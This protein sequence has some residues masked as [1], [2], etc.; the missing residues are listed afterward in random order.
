M[1]TKT[2]V[3]MFEG[4]Y[5]Y[6]DAPLKRIGHPVSYYSAQNFVL[7]CLRVMSYEYGPI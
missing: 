7:L 1:T 4:I 3:N 5:I 2:L 6:A